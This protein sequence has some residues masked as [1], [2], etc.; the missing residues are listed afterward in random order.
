M[1][2]V[3][4]DTQRNDLR[5]ETKLSSACRDIHKVLMINV[6]IPENLFPVTF[7][8]STKIKHLDRVPDISRLQKQE[9]G[10]FNAG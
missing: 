5:L 1:K 7:L 8:Y 9:N 6:W 4:P 3:V 2:C 10:F